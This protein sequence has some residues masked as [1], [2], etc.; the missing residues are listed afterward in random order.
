[1][2]HPPDGARLALVSELAPA[3]LAGEPDPFAAEL[4]RAVAGS[5]DALDARITAASRDWPADRLGTL[6]RNILRIGIHELEEGAV[7]P[8]VAVMPP[9]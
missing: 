9:T 2:G 6:E 1:M 7:P 4:A 8:E 3:L 5:A